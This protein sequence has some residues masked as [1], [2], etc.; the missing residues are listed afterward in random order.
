MAC[1]CG[2]PRLSYAS[3][4]KECNKKYMRKYMKSKYIKKPKTEKSYKLKQIVFLSTNCKLYREN[5][6]EFW[7]RKYR[8]SLS[9]E[10]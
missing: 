5:K 1:K 8:K 2:Q 9:E 10:L 7:V 6:V 3:R 4:C